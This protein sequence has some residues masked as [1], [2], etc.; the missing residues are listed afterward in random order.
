MRDVS[1][2]LVSKAARFLPAVLR[3]ETAAATLDST[4]GCIP[5]GYCLTAT[6]ICTGALYLFGQFWDC[7]GSCVPQI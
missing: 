5:V 4:N 2:W 3:H 6:E 1:E 7:C